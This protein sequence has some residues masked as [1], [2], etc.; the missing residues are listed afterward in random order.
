MLTTFLFLNKPGHTS[1]GYTTVPSS[2]QSV[3][4]KRLDHANFTI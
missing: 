3:K 2:V 1:G 4:L